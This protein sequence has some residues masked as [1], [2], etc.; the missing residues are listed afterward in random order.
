GPRRR[1]ASAQARRGRV[2]SARYGALERRAGRRAAL[3][4]RGAAEGP[5]EESVVP[6]R[7]RSQVAA[8]LITVAAIGLAVVIVA[9]LLFGAAGSYSVHAIFE[10]AS[11]LVRGDQVKVGGVSVGSVT[12]I[13]LDDRARARVTLSIDDDSLTPLHRGSRVEV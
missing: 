9:F 5:R 3:A 2:A 10:N 6:V 1:E 4:S 11:Q 7:R 13:E 12:G 8:R